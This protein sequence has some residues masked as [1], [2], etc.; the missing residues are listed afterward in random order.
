[1]A[2][3]IYKMQNILDVK[4]NLETQAKQEFGQAVFRLNE[5]KEK[6]ETIRNRRVEYIKHYQDIIVNRIDV[7]EITLTRTGITMTEEEIKKQLSVVRTAERNVEVARKKLEKVVQERKIQEKLKE[8]AFEAFQ[9]ELLMQEQKEID[10]L[11]SFR[12]GQKL[13]EEETTID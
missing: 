13:E 1:M 10:E 12:Y 9:K 7:M 8:K 11:V 6:L 2:K 5:E 4:I 3:F